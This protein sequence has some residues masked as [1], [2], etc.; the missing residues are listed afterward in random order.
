M[1]SMWYKLPLGLLVSVF[2]GLASCDQ[3]FLEKPDSSD[4]TIDTI[5]STRLKAETFLWETYKTCV[6]VGF[7]FDWGYHNGMYAS[8]LVGACD[9]GDVYDSWPGSN[10]HNTGGWSA[11]S[12]NEDQ[13]GAHYKG[14]RNAN[15][16][17][18]NIER[19]T[20]ISAEEVARYRAEA[21]VLRALQHAELL[22]RYGGIPIV[23]HVLTSSGTV[24]I[25]RNTYEESVD[26][27]VN[28]CDEAAAVLPDNYPTQFRGR[29]TKG[30]ALALKGRVLLYAASELHNTNDPYMTDHRELTGYP[31]YSADRWQRAANANKDLLDW[32]ANAGVTLVKT[33]ADAGKNY[34]I[35][36]TEPDNS[37]IILGNK[38]SGWWGA[39]SPMYQQFAMPRGV[40]GGWYGHG[41]TLQ[42]AMRYQTVAGNDQVWPDEGTES[43]YLQKMQELEPRFQQSVFYSGSSWNTEYG[44]LKFYQKKDGTWFG[45]APLNGAGYM[46]KFLTRLNWGG[47]QLN[48][49]VFRLAEFYLNYAE[50]LNEATPLAAAAFDA[51]NEVRLRAGLPAI[52]SADPRYDTQDELRQAIRR[53]RAVELAFEEHRFFDVRRW[54]IAEQE[55]VMKGSMWELN[56]YEQPDNS[57]RYKKEVFESR[58]WENKMY[59]YPFPQS[60]I[61]KRYLIQNPGW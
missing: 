3:D 20:E 41:V 44:T 14:I 19:V 56:L 35:A 59:L 55:G 60:E 54:K 42:H 57:I 7:P 58:V 8:M 40:Y 33:E 4:V 28:S 2:F 26:F 47:G 10:S 49:P 31:S 17:M 38:A 12:N 15:I 46:K 61:D 50:A 25:P 51:V 27:I 36:V 9:E 21:N 6:P 48:W 45:N 53:E 39:W 34:E 37:E 13:L 1:K 16:F 18:A 11:V 52:S 32:A 5:F 30:A 24:K 23:D 43:E 22:K 29:I